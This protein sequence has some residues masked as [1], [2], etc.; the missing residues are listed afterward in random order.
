[1]SR[2]YLASSWK[3]PYY[4]EVLKWLRADL[5][6]VYDFRTRGY[7]R[8]LGHGSFECQAF[9][10]EKLDKK[11]KQW[12]FEAYRQNLTT[13]PLAAAGFLSDIKAIEWCDTLVLLLPSGRSAHLEAGYAKG[14][15]KRLVIFC[16]MKAYDE[17]DLMYLMADNIV[18]SYA[19]LE[20][21]IT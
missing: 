12:N 9:S 18:G 11:W 7:Q 19:E 2:I 14:R 6:Q 8:D 16:P 1:M 17:P 5:H 20:S 3:N 4:T 21:V 15:G 13:K 10:W